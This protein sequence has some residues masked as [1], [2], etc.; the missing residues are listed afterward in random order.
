MFPEVF[1]RPHVQDRG[2]ESKNERSL[3]DEVGTF[4]VGRR[5]YNR[6]LGGR[7]IKRGEKV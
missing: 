6:H 5:T 3:T 2:Q 1:V 7:E 4:V